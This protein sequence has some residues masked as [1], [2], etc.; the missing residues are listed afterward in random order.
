M[1]LRPAGRAARVVGAL[2]VLVACTPTSS[3]TPSASEP[4]APD[5]SAPATVGAAPSPDASAGLASDPLHTVELYDVNS[6]TTFTLGELAADRPVLFEMMA[7]WCTNCRAQQHQVVA[8]H[9]LAAFHSVSLDVDP[10]ERP[11]DLADYSAEQ[12]FGWR[13]ALADQV[14]ASALRERFGPAVLNPP[15]TPMVLLFP[16]GTVRALE[17]RAYPAEELAAEIAAG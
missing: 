14:L 6:M 9:D 4:G 7:I 13:F 3:A 12:G 15:S 8:A 17:F 2:I 11:E 1:P 5:P 16:D 10:N